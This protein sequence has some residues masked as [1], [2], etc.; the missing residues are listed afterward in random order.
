M[1]ASTL[2][3]SAFKGDALYQRR[4]RLA[5]PILIRQ[6][7]AAQTLTYGELGAELDMPNPRNLNFVLGSVAR[8]L[9]DLSE[10]WGEQIP[11]LTTLIVDKYT[12][13]PSDGIVEFFDEP[14]SYLRAPSEQRRLLVDRLLSDVYLYSRWAEVLEHWNLVPSRPVDHGVSRL[15]G[16]GAESAAHVAL[17]AY[18]AANPALVGLPSKF[19]PG[20]T[21]EYLPSGDE[22]DVL[23][24]GR[25]REIGVEV[26]TAAA[27]E[28]EIVRGLYQCV[29]YDAILRARQR[30]AQAAADVEVFLVLGGVLPKRL[31]PLRNVL[32][33]NVVDGV[34]PNLS[35]VHTARV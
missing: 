14:E 19:A 34:D 12:K 15:P 6:A 28:E 5:L 17:K 22:I 33:V 18:V 4:G 9:V 35:L 31:V 7:I 30:A 24:T 3:K 26:K 21:E 27:P 10:D 2:A 8:A 32:G 20:R 23:F 1:G 16:A 11:R 25:G 13:L 29:K